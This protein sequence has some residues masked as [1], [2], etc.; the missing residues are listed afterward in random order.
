[1]GKKRKKKK[2]PRAVSEMRTG[3]FGRY[4]AWEVRPKQRFEFCCVGG[5]HAGPGCDHVFKANG[6]PAGCPQCHNVYVENVRAA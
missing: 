4:R 3:E 6:M 5:A 1:M 2:Q